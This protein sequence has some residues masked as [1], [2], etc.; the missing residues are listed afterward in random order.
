MGCIVFNADTL[1][2]FVDGI[3]KIVERGEFR[4]RTSR[5]G[6]VADGQR[7]EGTGRRVRKQFGVDPLNSRRACHAGASRGNGRRTTVFANSIDRVKEP[8]ITVEGTR[9]ANDEASRSRIG[10]K[11][12]ATRRKENKEKRVPGRSVDGVSDSSGVS[13]PKA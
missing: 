9:S 6:L 5:R 2:G 4:G 12:A 13:L 11:V 3:S 1:G 8:K 7:F 10:E